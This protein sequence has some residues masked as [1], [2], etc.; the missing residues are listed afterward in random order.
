M[1]EPLTPEQLD[2]IERRCNRASPSPWKS[3][4]EGRDHTSGDSFIMTGGPDIYLVGATVNDQDFIA[5]A[6]QDLPLLISEIRR[7]RALRA[8]DTSD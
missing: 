8:T 7:L 6:R 1:A 2:E 4:V 3:H 5:A